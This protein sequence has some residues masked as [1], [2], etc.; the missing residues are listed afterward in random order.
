MRKNKTLDTIHLPVLADDARVNP[1]REV[2][3]GKGAFRKGHSWL[4]LIF[5]LIY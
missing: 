5:L 1:G 3:R 4:L 2:M